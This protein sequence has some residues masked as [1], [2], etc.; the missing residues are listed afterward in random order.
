[1]TDGGQADWIKQIG[2]KNTDGESHS[3]TSREKVKERERERDNIWA[4][5]FDHHQQYTEKKSKT[6]SGEHK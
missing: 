2:T 4:D 6:V 1:M 3:M 5:S